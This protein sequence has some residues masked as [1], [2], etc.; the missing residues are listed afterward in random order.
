M[1]RRSS[2]ETHRPKKK[3]VLESKEQTKLLVKDVTT[4]GARNVSRYLALACQKKFKKKKNFEKGA[5][6][7][8]IIKY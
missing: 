4:W 6:I 8:I 7:D 2:P 3:K 1:K 5:Y